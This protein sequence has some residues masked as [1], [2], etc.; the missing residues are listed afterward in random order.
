MGTAGRRRV[1]EHFSTAVILPQNEAF[2]QRYAWGNR[3][4]RGE[5]ASAVASPA[6]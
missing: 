4:S 5:T 1:E 6:S 3:S 2:Y